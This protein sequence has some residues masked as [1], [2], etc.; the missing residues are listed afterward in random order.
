MKK[1]N[2]ELGYVLTDM[3]GKVARI[4]FYHPTH[5]AL[6]ATLLSRL[7]AVIRRIGKNTA[8][9]VII[10]QSAGDR[11]FCAGANFDELL[12]I[13]D[14]IAGKTFFSGFAHVINAIRLARQPIIGRIHG[15]AIGGAVGLIAA[16]DYCFANEHAEIKLS[17]LS[18]GLGPFVIA[19]VVQR[20]IGLGKLTELT[21]NPKQFK[22]AQ[23]SLEA[24]LYQVVCGSTALMDQEIGDFCLQLTSY[25]ASALM[26]IKKTLWKGAENWD[27]L[28]LNQAEITGKLVVD[29][30][31]KTLLK[32]FKASR[33]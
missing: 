29:K 8:I 11:T 9:Q 22:T 25:S 18:I 6:P 10:L 30:K 5:N 31:T 28:L 15:K 24:G 1:L 4:T 21:F 33:K 16:C 3:Q 32:R 19:P 26:A 17:E 14:E 23:W 20:K 7:A 12:T 27:T 2:Q 13:Q